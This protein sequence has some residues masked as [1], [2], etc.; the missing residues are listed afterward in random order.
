MASAEPSTTVS[1]TRRLVVVVPNIS[2][3]FDR[4]EPLITKLQELDGYSEPGC[5]WARV[6]HGGN[7]WSRS[8][9]D[10]GVE[11][12]ATIHSLW[13]AHGGFSSIVL[14]GH[15]LGGICLR[16]AYMM[17]RGAFEPAD[18]REWA[19]H[20][21]RIVLFASLNRG[22]EVSWRRAWW[23]PPV[24]FVSRRVPQFR[25]WIGRDV[26][27]GSVFISSL[28]TSWIREINEQ[29]TP[30]IVTQFL[31]TRDGLMTR[32]DS[33]DIETF[34]TGYQELIPG[35]THSDLIELDLSVE[36]NQRF[37]LI[38]QAFERP[39]RSV[40]PIGEKEQRIVLVLHGIRA[41]NEG[42]PSKIAGYIADT[43]KGTKAVPATYG[44][45]TAIQF[46]FPGT[47]RKF[48]PWLQDTYA[49]LLAENPQATFHFIGH[50]NGTY[51]LGES[52]KTIPAMKFERVALIGSVLPTQ[53][54]WGDRLADEQI[55]QL[56]NDRGASDVPVGLL[57]GGLRGLG[58]TDVGTA[59]VE[60]FRWQQ[61][62]KREVFYY[63]GGHS[64]ALESDENLYRIARFAMDGAVEDPAPDFTMRDTVRFAWLFQAAQ[65]LGRGAAVALLALAG[66]FVVC[67]PWAWYFDLA[68]VIG[69]IALVLIVVDTI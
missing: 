36:S 59:G 49:Q 46:M 38:R 27:R 65:W 3:K 20:V 31:G 32:E 30:P 55:V 39:Q 44:R 10:L 69:V 23:I 14:V 54:P 25:D 53:Y 22:I 24:D 18:A 43:W 52:L 40:D 37:A 45:F 15:S 8:A 21:E 29:N 34:P 35:A 1:A 56:R 41:S 50:S 6:H 63:P 13:Q 17:A 4:W 68:A 57:C 51:L 60:G 64:K 62:G 26:V 19:D 7:R 61:A 66:W 16:Y 9:A 28:R 11:V 47:R 48:L 33:R 42:W 67:S 58:M 2:D 5:L 12:G